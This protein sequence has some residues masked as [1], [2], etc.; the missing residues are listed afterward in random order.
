MR[1]KFLIAVL[2]AFAWIPHVLAEESSE[3]AATEYL[4]IAE[5]DLKT[6]TTIRVAEETWTLHLGPA[7]FWEDKDFRF[8]AGD[9]LVVVGEL[10]RSEESVQLYPHKIIRGE[11]QIVLA[12]EAGIPI[13]ARGSRGFG[14][15]GV[16][17]R[18]RN[19][20]Q[21]RQGNGHH[22]GR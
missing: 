8:L 10:V 14:V 15:E 16:R 11:E 20:G 19:Q 7:W 1:K 4:V 22:W 13:W 21:G 2:I 12:N 6:L 17:G 3:G 9:T 5:E 18:S